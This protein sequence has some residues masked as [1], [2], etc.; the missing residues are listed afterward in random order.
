M[1]NAARTCIIGR[2][3]SDRPNI[4]LVHADQHRWDCLGAYGHG[5]V[6]TP[7]IDALAADGVRWAESFC[8]FPV[9]TPSRYSLLTGLYVR[10]HLGGTNHSTLPAGL[11]TFPR[12]LKDAGYRTKAVGKMHFTPTYL[13]VGFEEMAL[14][15]Q[16]GPGRYDD[17]YHRW[18]RSEGLCD[19]LDLTDQVREYRRQAPQAYWQAFGALRSDLDEAHHSTTWIADR[20]VETLERWGRGGCLLMVG[21]V[22]PHHPFDPPAPWDRMYEPGAL[23]VLPGWT[24]EPLPRDL[25]FRRGYFPC[26]E[27]TAPQLRRVMALYYATI[28]QIDHHV[29]RMVD[30]LRARGLY[31]NTLIVYTSD[32][33]DYMGFHHL[34]L[35]GNYMYDPLV[36]VPL[37]VKFPDG[38][39]RGEVS[40]AMVSNVDV[41]PTLLRQAG[42]DVP[43]AMT[44]LDLASERGRRGRDVIFAEG[45]AGQQVMAR[46]RTRKLLL[47]RDD[48]HSQFLDLQADPLETRNLYREPARR[49]EIAELTEALLRWALL[50][51]PYRIHLDDSAL[52]VAG[53]NVPDRGDGHVEEGVEYFRRRMSEPF[54]LSP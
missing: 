17:D 36:R 43:G 8:P 21:F 50:D 52:I 27:M 24:D 9:C 7:N 26:E 12:V 31:D 25:A 13:D 19:R 5:D 3:M 45:G 15:E 20:A 54:D 47:C 44:G 23:S 2:T 18:L 32:H 33:G 40:D 42:C 1:D 34:I 39:R 46:T 11:A 29:G 49:G 37:I 16:D 30:C 4:L 10:Q 38:H 28:S 53:D 41:A 22:K 14:A 6:R 35:K 51:E 48:A